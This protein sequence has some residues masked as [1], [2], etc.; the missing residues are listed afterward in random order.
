MI[1]PTSV[2]PVILLL[3]PS[4]ANKTAVTIR[5]NLITLE[6][7]DFSEVNRSYTDLDLV[8]DKMLLVLMLSKD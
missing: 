6:G 8:V 3:G 2:E 7:K 5:D 1:F 4:Q